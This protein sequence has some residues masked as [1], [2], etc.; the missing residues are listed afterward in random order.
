MAAIPA[1]CRPVTNDGS[2]APAL[3]APEL[4]D[5]IGVARSILP[6]VDTVVTT[7]GINPEGPYCIGP[8]FRAEG[9]DILVE[10]V[11]PPVDAT[12]DEGATVAEEVRALVRVAQGLLALWLGAEDPDWTDFSMPLSPW[13]RSFL[14][15]RADVFA[16]SLLAEFAARIPQI[17]D[18]QHLLE[19]LMD[20]HVGERSLMDVFGTETDFPLYDEL[21]A[22]WLPL[23]NRAVVIFNSPFDQMSAP[24]VPQ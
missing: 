9:L 17:V 14:A 1:A 23:W 18:R 10:L 12:R 15:A 21:V 16:G 8:Q 22:Y 5:L 19:G 6:V 7:C 24:P 13:A 3:L 4:K 2:R 20:S 11:L